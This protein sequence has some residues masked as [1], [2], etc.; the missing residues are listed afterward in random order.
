MKK[1][2]EENKI[3]FFTC[4]LNG[5]LEEAEKIHFEREIEKSEKLRIEFEEFKTFW[6]NLGTVEVPEVTDINNKYSELKER[7][8]FTETEVK[9]NRNFISKNIYHNEIFNKKRELFGWTIRFAALLLLS[10]ILYQILIIDHSRQTTI[11]AANEQ[12]E[13]YYHIT[14]RG[15]RSEIILPDESKVYLNSSS[16][17]SYSSNFNENQRLVKLEGEAFF[18]IEPNKNLPFIVK[19]KH[20]MV[21]VVGTKFNVYNRDDEFVVAV[22]EGKVMAID[23]QGSIVSLEKNQ[24]AE[25]KGNNELVKTTG[26]DIEQFI[27][28]RKEKL[29]FKNEP[30]YKVMNEIELTFNINTFFKESSL[31]GR[32]LTGSFDARSLNEILTAI[33]ISLNVDFE[34][35]GN[36]IIIH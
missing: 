10:I 19:T 12:P 18:E 21:K 8:K 28:W 30:L 31:R 33:S 24:A 23:N 2:T 3:D 35:E 5:E 25:M 32:K 36:R 14:K 29:A 16:R 27:D 6:K 11:T 9:K 20:N 4:Y 7:I 15:E 22:S 34:K 13:E 26:I 17:L 1:I